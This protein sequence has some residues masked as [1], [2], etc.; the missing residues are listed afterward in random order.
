MVIAWMLIAGTGL[1]AAQAATMETVGIRA[2]TSGACAGLDLRK[3]AVFTLT[4]L[5]TGNEVLTY[6]RRSDGT[7]CPVGAFATGGQSDILGIIVSGQNPVIADG[8][9]VFAIN[10]GSAAGTTG[11]GSV[12]VM[13]IEADRLVLTDMQPSGGPNP[14]AVTKLGDKVYVVNSGYSPRLFGGLFPPIPVTIQGYRFDA[15]TGHLSPIAGSLAP[16]L[17]PDGDPTQIE[18]TPD[19]KFLVVAQ[20]RT[21]EVRETPTSPR[22]I[23]VFPVNTDGT[24]GAPTRHDVGGDRPFGFRIGAGNVVYLTHGQIP[25]AYPG[26]LSA[27]RINA[28]GSVETITPFIAD[29]DGESCWNYISRTTRVPYHY[30]SAYFDSAIGQSRIEP[31]GRLTLLQPRLA[32]SG[33]GFGGLDMHGTVDAETGNEYLYVLNNPVPMPASQPIVRIVGY[34]I[35]PEDG[36]LTQLGDSVASGINNDGFGLWSQ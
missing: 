29:G 2:D 5:R 22:Y 6:A 32:Q 25:D 15:D 26:G 24:P 7:L 8:G 18:F 13:R 20:R 31:D 1:T 4:N 3:G 23:E 12:S 30:S 28:D 10:P 35:N 11:D 19:G 27:H 14:R 9:Y 33:Q 36:A 21:S 34:R 17:D 16:T